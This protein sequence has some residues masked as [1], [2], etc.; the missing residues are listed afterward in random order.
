MA[1]DILLNLRRPGEAIPFLMT[2]LQKDP[3]R[4]QANASLGSAYLSTGETA[5][6]IPHLKL[7]LEADQDG[8]RHYQLARAYQREGE[9]AL[10]SEMLRKHQEIQEAQRD[11]EE[12]FD[13]NVQITPP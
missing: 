10:A 3:G 5:K 9:T 12:Q 1:G 7:A 13:R 6:A 4:V 8:S 2:A 11:R